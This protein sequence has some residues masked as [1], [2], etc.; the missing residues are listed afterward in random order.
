MLRRICGRHACISRRLLPGRAPSRAAREL[1]VHGDRRQGAR[2]RSPSPMAAGLSRIFSRQLPGMRVVDRRRH[3]S[4]EE[5]GERTSLCRLL[6]WEQG[7][8]VGRYDK[9]HLFD[10]RVP[11]SSEAYMSR[12]AR[13]PATRPGAADPVRAARHRR[14]LRPALSRTLPLYAG[15]RGERDCIPAAFT[16]RTGE[17]HWHTLIKARAI[18]NLCYLALPPRPAN[19]PGGGARMVTRWSWGPG[20]KYWRSE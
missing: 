7:R 13:C 3:Y 10:V 8:R 16:E 20:A 19:I 1:R 14:V 5:Q 4:F 11:D 2:S 6:V 18:E 17:A 15:S 12:G 9:I